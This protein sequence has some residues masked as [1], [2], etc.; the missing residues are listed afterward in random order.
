MNAV[1]IKVDSDAV[2]TVLIAG[3]MIAAFSNSID[4]LKR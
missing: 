4:L 1:L 3:V 2:L